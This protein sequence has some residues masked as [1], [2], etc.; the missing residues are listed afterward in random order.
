MNENFFELHNIAEL[1]PSA[2]YPGPLIRRYP[3]AVAEALENSSCVSEDASLSE[4]RFVVVS[5]RRLAVSFTAISGGD[6]FIYRGDFLQNHVRVPAGAAFRH[7]LDFE[8][9][10]Y[11]N[12]LPEAFVGQA[13]SRHVWRVVF[14][15]VTLLHGVDRMGAVIRPPRADEKPARRWAAYGSSITHGY[16][17]VTRQQ[18]YVAQTARRLG[19][20]V[21][22]LGLSGSCMCEKSAVDYLASRDDWD[23]ITCEVGVNMRAHYE[24][25]VFDQRVRNLVETLTTSRPGKPVVL[26]SPFTSAADFA[27]EPT[28][29]SRRT[30]G[31][32][33]ALTAIVA[34]F[35]PR[36]VQLLD[37]REILPAFAGLTCDFVHPSTEGHTLMAENLANQLRSFGIA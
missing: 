2:G 10:A 25:D 5:G 21:I 16:S 3:R 23:F 4:L 31:F 22:N 12:L 28:R 13:F 20:D 27:R 17:P 11:A 34:E 7:V 35:A 37:G 33:E 26:I 24:P 32:R 18:C 36:G 6:L 30:A 15:G 14:D 19:V 29:D 8:N 9:D 1:D